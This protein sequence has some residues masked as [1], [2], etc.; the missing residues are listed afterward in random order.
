MTIREAYLV[1]ATAVAVFD[2]AA[3]IYCWRQDRRRPRKP[4]SMKVLDDHARLERHRAR[5]RGLEAIMRASR[6]TG[7][8]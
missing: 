2:T 4:S 3:L 8:S 6:D 1:L 7:A 5:E